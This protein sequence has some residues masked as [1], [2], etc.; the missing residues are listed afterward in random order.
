MTKERKREE[1][2]RFTVSFPKTFL[3]EIDIICASNFS[4]RTSWLIQAAKEKLER[5]RIE[6]IKKLKED[7]K[8]IKE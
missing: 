2:V 5:D 1:A 3:N 7:I 4:S 8:E 6:K